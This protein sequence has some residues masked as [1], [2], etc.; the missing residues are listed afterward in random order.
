MDSSTAWKR[1]A[2]TPS[3]EWEVIYRN[4]G[5][6]AARLDARKGAPDGGFLAS[7]R[8]RSH[9]GAG[10]GRRDVLGRAVPAERRR[11]EVDD[12]PASH[13]DGRD[14]EGALLVRGRRAH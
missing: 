9:I 2:A 7:Q 4:I 11:T 10:A 5:S 14:P 12:S 3:P 8:D 13:R 6:T 1:S